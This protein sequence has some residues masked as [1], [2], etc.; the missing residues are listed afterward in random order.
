MLQLG[1]ADPG[2]VLLERSCH[3]SVGANADDQGG[4]G[5][6]FLDWTNHARNGF[7]D[8]EQDDAS[9]DIIVRSDWQPGEESRGFIAT[10]DYQLARLGVLIGCSGGATVTRVGLF[11]TRDI[12]RYPGTTSTAVRRAGEQLPPAGQW[13]GVNANFTLTLLSVRPQTT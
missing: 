6:M 4:A 13:A 10:P 1:V 3:I 8:C 7:L 12:P 11:A 2:Y 9:Y 5:P